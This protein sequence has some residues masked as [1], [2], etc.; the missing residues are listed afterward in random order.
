MSSILNNNTLK[1]E[2]LSESLN[3]QEIHNE[4]IHLFPDILLPWKPTILAYASLSISTCIGF[5]ID[6]VKTRMQSQYNFKGYCDCIK[7]TYRFEGVNGFFRGLKVPIFANAISR[8]LTIL[9]FLK[10]K[11]ILNDSVYCLEK[12]KSMIFEGQICFLSGAASAGIISVF[13]CAFDS[14]KI[15]SQI[16]KLV[17]KDFSYGLTSSQLQESKQDISIFSTLKKT[18]KYRGLSGLYSG[19]KFHFLRDTLSGGIYYSTYELTKLVLNSFQEISLK[20]SIFVSGGIAGVLGGLV[21]FPLDTLKSLVNK[22]L[23]S[24]IIRIENGLN[25]LPSK[26]NDFQI[27]HRGVY[28]GIMATVFRAFIANLIFFTIFEFSM[29]NLH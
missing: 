1:K 7:K 20:T 26:T 28:K 12:T 2:K 5:P 27:L 8:S 11:P 21:A 19:F 10:I 24:D 17:Q 29:A 22:N 25:S 9:L 23:M 18:V 6:A 13:T 4:K 14:L 16:L 3:T 15:Q